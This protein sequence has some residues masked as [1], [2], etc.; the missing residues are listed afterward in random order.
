MFTVAIHTVNAAF[1]GES[2]PQ[3][4]AAEVARI[5]RALADKMNGPDEFTDL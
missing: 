2:F 1:G 3:D 4:C 5:L